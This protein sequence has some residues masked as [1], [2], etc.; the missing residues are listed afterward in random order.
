MEPFALFNLLKTLLP[1]TENHEDPHVSSPP[2]TPNAT[3]QKPE[4]NTPAPS[5]QPLPSNSF[6]EFAERHDERAKRIKKK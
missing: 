2:Q 3:V 1:Q 5:A 6:L 4:E